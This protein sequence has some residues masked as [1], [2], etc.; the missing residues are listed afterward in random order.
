MHPST[1]SS[2]MSHGESSRRLHDRYHQTPTSAHPSP[3]K[4]LARI[5]GEKKIRLL[6]AHEIAFDEKR[7]LIM[8][9]RQKLPFHTNGMRFIAYAADGSELW[10]R[11]T[12]TSGARMPP[13]GSHL[14]D[15][16]GADLIANWIDA[17][18]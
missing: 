11:I 2:R 16:A 17:L 13:I 1:L 7:D 8:N 9:K 18:R 14:V 5:R 15:Q 4:A 10:R 6:G 3:G 12:S